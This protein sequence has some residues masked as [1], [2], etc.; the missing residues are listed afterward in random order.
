MKNFLDATFPSNKYTTGLDVTDNI[1]QIVNAETLPSLN[2][3]TES[4]EFLPTQV[5][6]LPHAARD[7]IKRL[8]E[9]DPR[10]RIHSVLTLQRI[11]LYQNYKIDS[12]HLLSVSCLLLF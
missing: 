5:E 6:R 3:T 10:K 12:K 7:V 11:A 9:F 4:F 2:Y 1:V 8:L